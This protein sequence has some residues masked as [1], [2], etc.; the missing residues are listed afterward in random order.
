MRVL[1][2]RRW[3]TPAVVLLSAAAA[4]SCTTAAPVTQ[5]AHTTQQTA[6]A[7]SSGTLSSLLSSITP[8]TTSARTLA[9]RPPSAAPA[10]TAPAPPYAFPVVP[11]SHVTF[12]HA[13]H[14]YPAT[15]V[16]AR[17]GDT[18]RAATSGRVVTVSRMDSW[19][20]SINSG[21]T[22]GG[23][24]VTFVGDDGVRYYGSHLRAIAPALR[25]GERLSAGTPLGAVGN[26]GD[27]RYVFCHVHFGI[28]PPC[29]AD[30]NDWWNRR[31]VLYPWPYLESWRVNGQRSPAAAV[32][33]WR[34]THGCPRSA[35]VD[36]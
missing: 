26:T 16:R 10:A 27:A 31:G 7:P 8:S 11:L 12:V 20:P 25:V 5:R 23:L 6:P 34:S 2:R 21:A 4:C 22:R 19:R 24:S 17:C 14:D 29:T 3:R 35:T 33:T 18:Y 9:T 13:H 1:V 32:R 36:G 28:S 15:D 30:G